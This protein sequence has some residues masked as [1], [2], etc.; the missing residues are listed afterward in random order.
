[1]FGSSFNSVYANDQMLV[2]GN[3]NTSSFVV[4]GSAD[5]DNVF[6]V[7]AA[8][9]PT[10]AEDS[11]TPFSLHIGK[12]QKNLTLGGVNPDIPCITSLDTTTLTF[13]A[14]LST[15]LTSINTIQGKSTFKD[16]TTVFNGVGEASHGMLITNQFRVSSGGSVLCTDPQQRLVV[17]SECVVVYDSNTYTQVN[18][19]DALSIKAIDASS[20]SDEDANVDTVTVKA[21]KTYAHYS[22]VDSTTSTNSTTYHY[23]I[24]ITLSKPGKADVDDWCYFNMISELTTNSQ[25]N[26]SLNGL[27]LLEA[28]LPAD[29]VNRDISPAAKDDTLAINH[30]FNEA[31]VS[32]FMDTTINHDALTVDL[33]TKLSSTLLCDST[34]DGTPQ[35]TILSKGL[36]SSVD[37]NTSGGY[38]FADDGVHWNT[39]STDI[40]DSKLV[41]DKTS[42]VSIQGAL[43]I[44]ATEKLELT[45]TEFKA[46]TDL[47]VVGTESA[48]MKLP[49]AHVLIDS[50]GTHINSTTIDIGTDVTLTNNNNTTLADQDYIKVNS[51]DGLWLRSQNQP[52]VITSAHLNQY[53]PAGGTFQE[54]VLGA[55]LAMDGGTLHTI[56]QTSTT[57]QHKDGED[58]SSTVK[59][60][61]DRVYMAAQGQNTD[62]EPKPKNI[63]FGTSAALT[64][65]TITGADT[66]APGYCQVNGNITTQRVQASS[67]VTSATAEDVSISDNHIHM[68]AFMAGGETGETAKDSGIVS[69]CRT[70]ATHQ[71]SFMFSGDRPVITLNYSSEWN[72]SSNTTAVAAGH[73]ISVYIDHAS[74]APHPA[75]GLYIL[76]EIDA[77]TKVLTLEKPSSDMGVK[78]T[79]QDLSVMTSPVAVNVSRVGVSHLYMHEES[80]LSTY[81]HIHSHGSLLYAHGEHLSDFSMDKYANLTSG[82]I[83]HSYEDVTTNDQHHTIQHAVTNVSG[84]GLTLRLPGAYTEEVSYLIDGSEHL[85]MALEKGVTLSNH[86]IQAAPQQLY[87]RSLTTVNDGYRHIMYSPSSSK[88]WQVDT[89]TANPLLATR[90]GQLM[91]NDKFKVL[92]LGDN[93]NRY[94]TIPSDDGRVITTEES[95]Q[96]ISITLVDASAKTVRLSAGGKYVQLQSVDVESVTGTA[97]ASMIVSSNTANE[98]SIFRYTLNVD[99]SYSF[100]DPNEPSRALRLGLGDLQ[101]RAR[102]QNGDGSYSNTP[103]PNGAV[104]NHFEVQYGFKL[105]PQTALQIMAYQHITLKGVSGVLYFRSRETY[106]TIPNLYKRYLFYHTGKGWFQVEH[107]C[108]F[109][110]DLTRAN[111]DKFVKKSGFY[112]Q[113]QAPLDVPY[114]TGTVVSKADATYYVFEH[115]TPGHSELIVQWKQFKNTNYI[116]DQWIHITHVTTIAPTSGTLI[117]TTA[118]GSN[119]LAERLSP[120]E[121][122]IITPADHAKGNLDLFTVASTFTS[123]QGQVFQAEDV[124]NIAHGVAITGSKRQINGFTNGSFP[125]GVGVESAPDGANA[126]ASRDYFPVQDRSKFIL[127]EFDT[128]TQIDNSASDANGAFV[129][130]TLSFPNTTEGEG[131]D[132]VTLKT[133]STFLGAE[134]HAG[135]TFTVTN[136]GASNVTV[137]HDSDD[138]SLIIPN[139]M[140]TFVYDGSTYYIST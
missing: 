93:T 71:G 31:I 132:T 6:S 69:T 111:G 8:S 98:A 140:S 108:K 134:A 15:G 16:G 67:M 59:T 80:Q 112:L 41:V 76:A 1:M 129:S 52:L 123:D 90:E 10:S 56:D 58:Q 3:S 97:L 13:D 92:A 103:N 87:Y 109:G 22:Y 136:S 38:K 25:F 130:D 101:T 68:N 131:G 83:N 91:N 117:T 51:T 28:L 17:G 64:T 88:W 32:R 127:Q 36:Q 11:G 128:R 96:T 46:C 49:N 102:V 55:G 43:V 73:I 60:D 62:P 9:A 95:G 42:G 77:T 75:S 110:G 20:G 70:F 7:T 137:K 34:S 124:I 100:T 24:R 21:D 86:L 33:N 106:G 99:G 39:A 2:T 118:N 120:D 122:R 104:M 27:K 85:R 114:P 81:N 29:N 116:G 23:I 79:K 44:D 125:F 89:I 53:T 19:Y 126:T 4:K 78:F 115:P 105:Q 26:N 57:L 107:A 113:G 135:D 5:S 65:V 82:D 47:L 119:R 14:G 12:S 121:P 63:S 72:L 50:T 84:S 35:K 37:I 66:V 94:M 138:A 30:I 48:S 45:A 61:G 40:L 74:N 54:L 18:G 139:Q 133:E